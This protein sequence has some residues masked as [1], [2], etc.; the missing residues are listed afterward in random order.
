MC[1]CICRTMWHINNTCQTSIT[2]VLQT[3]IYF[4]SRANKSEMCARVYNNSYS[5]LV[6]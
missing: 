6:K 4:T 2:S 3:R 1:R 5:H